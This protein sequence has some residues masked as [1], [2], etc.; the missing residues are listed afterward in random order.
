MKA[1]D[2]RSDTVTRPGPAMRAAMAAAEVGDD[3]YG[4]DPTVNALQDAAA[5][6]VGKEA[7]LF[8]PSGTMANQAAIRVLTAHGDLMLASEG[9]H[10]LR[11]ESG[12]A[13]A[14]SGVQIA[15]IGRAG[16]FDADDVRRAL[17]PPDHHHPPCT[18]VAVE[19]T[20]NTSGGRVFPWD[21]LRDVAACARERGLRLHLDGARLFNAEV[22][23][24]IPAARWAEPFDTVSFCFS[25]G[26]GAPV[27]S[28]VCGSAATVDRLHRVRK[29][30]GGGM[31][32]AGILAAAAL[33]ALEHNV[34]RLADDHANAAR[35]ARG[36]VELGLGVDPLPE[37]NIVLFGAPD[38]PDFAARLRESGVLVNSV[39]P[40]RF[41]AVTH[42]D[43]SS[44]DVDEALSRI[45][46]SC[47]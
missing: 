10:V 25:K 31:R 15:T 35:L 46:R 13:A 14:L 12:A 47:G 42:L 21:V 30:L 37:T 32:Q 34:A 17:T 6:R 16:V 27:G 1:I 33:H 4:E 9:A 28:V 24:G 39:S 38:R 3:V 20:H 8:V 43:V 41:R 26:L 19:N 18:L 2:L 29:M 36:L 22:A 45:R 40:G 5:R 44:E 11:Y 7:A 23:S